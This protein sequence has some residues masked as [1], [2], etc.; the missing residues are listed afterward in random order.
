MILEFQLGFDNKVTLV[1]DDDHNLWEKI[2]I[3]FAPFYMYYLLYHQIS[4]LLEIFGNP[5]KLLNWPTNPNLILLTNI[6]YS[7]EGFNMYWFGF[8]MK[9]PF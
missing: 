3:K 6:L 2:F 5:S 9:F 8:W 1:V 7:D 4:S